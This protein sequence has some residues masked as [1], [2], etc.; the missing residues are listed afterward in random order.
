M[1]FN[2]KGRLINLT[3]VIKELKTNCYSLLYSLLSKFIFRKLFATFF[4]SSKEVYRRNTSTEISVAKLNHSID[5]VNCFF[6]MFAGIFAWKPTVTP[7]VF[8]QELFCLHL[9][10]LWKPERTFQQ[11]RRLQKA[12]IRTQPFFMNTFLRMIKTQYRSSR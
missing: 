12:Q 9:L 3:S 5:L 8:Y 2:E 4:S 10:K 11:I 7:L 1:T 6:Q